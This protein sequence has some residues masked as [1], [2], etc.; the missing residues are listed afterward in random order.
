MPLLY[1]VKPPSRCHALSV[2]DVSRFANTENK[3]GSATSEGDTE[4]PH[5]RR[6]D[7]TMLSGV[8]WSLEDRTGAARDVISTAGVVL[9]HRKID[10]QILNSAILRLFKK[11]CWNSEVT[12]SPYK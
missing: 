11:K 9:N 1:A 8:L 3:V 5:S 6:R 7:Q 4:V 10:S 2:N 12:A